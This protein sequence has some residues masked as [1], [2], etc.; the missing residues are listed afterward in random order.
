MNGCGAYRSQSVDAIF[1]DSHCIKRF[2]LLMPELTHDDVFA[3]QVVF[4]W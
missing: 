3:W 4:E 1:I 2:A